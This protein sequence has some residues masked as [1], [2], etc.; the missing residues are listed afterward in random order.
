MP[1]ETT[2]AIVFATVV[3]FVLVGTAAFA[4]IVSRKDRE[5]RQKAMAQK[6][7]QEQAR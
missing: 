3:A 5:A 2:T 7:A 1:D 6:R 4:A